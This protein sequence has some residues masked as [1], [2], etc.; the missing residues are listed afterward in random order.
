MSSI[1]HQYVA[2][3][4]SG[5]EGVLAAELRGLPEVS[6]VKELRGAVAFNGPLR[7]G[8]RACMW[9][10]TASRMLIELGDFRGDSADALYDGIR[11]IDWLQHMAED[12]TLAVD[13]V[14]TSDGIRNSH[15]GAMRTKDAICDSI[16]ERMDIRP[17]VD[18]ERPDARVH[19]HLRQ[20]RFTVALDL[21]GDPLHRRGYRR[22][23]G[24][25]PIKES[26]AAAIL[27]LAEWPLAAEAGAPLVD[28]MCGSGTFLLEAAGIALDRAPG[29]GRSRWGFSRWRQHDPEAWS[30]VVAE[31]QERK[32][33]AND[34]EIGVFGADIDPEA[35]RT[36]KVNAQRAELPIVVRRQAVADSAPPD[37]PL[38]SPPFGLLVTNPPYGDRL[39]SRGGANQVGRELGRT[40]TR[41]YWGWRAVVIAGNRGL[42]ESI[43]LEPVRSKPL[44]NGP[45]E[46]RLLQFDVGD[47]PSGPPQGR[48]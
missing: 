11:Q 46:C 33:A 18:L 16:R 5:V 9:S 4:T 36:T 47:N 41:R 12:G 24:P 48:R 7:A 17:S 1:T 10:R 25:A 30:D 38:E 27:L 20:G 37:S 22:S 28:P 23:A 34:R 43:G 19:V 45:I 21:A 26:L 44:W 35:L 6:N 40:L 29:L 3:C 31:A 39:S 2:T 15:F 32:H 13:F 14:G 8:Y 42:A